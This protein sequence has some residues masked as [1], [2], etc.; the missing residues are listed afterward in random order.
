MQYRLDEK[1]GNRLSVLGFG[2]MRLPRGM[3]TRI[4][5]DQSEQLVLQAIERGVN[6]FDT[7][8]VYM[9]SEQAF[10]EI[11]RRNPAIR[12]KIFIATKLPHYQ[13]KT[14]DDFDR[15]FNRQLERLHT[16]Y[17]DYYLIHN[18]PTLASWQ[19]VCA[20]GVEK[21]IAEKKASGQIR[22]I[23]FSFHGIQEEFLNLLDVYDWDFCQIQYN[24]MNEN[25]QA[26]R[27]GLL[28]AHEKGLP[29]VIMEPLLGGKLAAG[30]PK[31]AETLFKN[32]VGGF[33]PAAWALRWVWHHKEATLLLSGMGSEAQVAENIQTAETA[34]PGMLTEK[35]MA[36][37]KQAEAIF[38][39]SYK[40]PCTG[41]NYCLPCPKGVNIPGCF[42][43]YNVSFSSGLIAG[44]SQYMTSTAVMNPKQNSG[45]A[46]C[47]KCGKCEKQ[48]PQHIRIMN[49]LEAVSKRMEPF[50]VRAGIKLFAQLRK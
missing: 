34:V 40:I 4:D 23:G 7:A 9:G 36:T 12:A 29:V 24:Y 22:Q 39:E 38:K 45:P 18:V 10:G 43:G 32:A 8:Y 44:I 25:Y 41:C 37:I 15:I 11:I 42:A 19:A 49:A 13:C 2:L 48:C 6:Y 33:S 35:E 28:K 21:W 5:I 16:D 3:S 17:I 31:K 26:G 14:Y 27:K 47:V 20:I 46:N 1:S 30:L 50:W